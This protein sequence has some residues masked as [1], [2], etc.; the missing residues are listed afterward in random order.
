MG[1]KRYRRL[2]VTE[3][4]GYQNAGKPAIKMQGIWLTEL[5]F[6]L[7]DKICVEC[8]NGRLTVTKVDEV[9]SA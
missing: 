3:Q 4:A 8:E 5:G 1:Y 7:G 9:R 6:N 2:T